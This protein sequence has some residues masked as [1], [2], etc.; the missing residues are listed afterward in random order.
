MLTRALI[1]L[2]LILNLGVA[3]WWLL[4]PS[5][6]TRDMPMQPTGIPLL[7][8]VQ[9]PS[10]ARQ[11]DPAAAPPARTVETGSEREAVADATPKLPSPRPESDPK[12]EPA[13]LPTTRAICVN[14]GPYDQQ[15]LAEQGRQRL[16]AINQRASVRQVPGSG[17]RNYRVLL[18]AQADKQTAQAI[19]E[20]IGQAGF[21][22]YLLI[23]AGNEANSIALGVYGS[24]DSALKRQSALQAA[25]F[26]AQ[27][28][29]T[30]EKNPPQWWLNVRTDASANVEQLKTTALAATALQ[31][32]CAV[33]G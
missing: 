5:T 31:Q 14:L 10:P 24:R 16:D 11:P 21:K 2:L 17:A 23:G 15:A 22:D 8:L 18:P 28:V 32:A 9:A 13:K 29:A 1:V 3:A 7:Q 12:P 33:L 30:G 6:E 25:G 4:K 20:R 26:D 27:I 19:V